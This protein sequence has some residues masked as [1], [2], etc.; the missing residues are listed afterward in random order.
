ME[1][2]ILCVSNRDA[3]QGYLAKKLME[4]GSTVVLCEEF[5]PKM[6]EYDI[7]LL[8]VILKDLDLEKVTEQLVEGQKVFGGNIP[9]DFWNICVKKGVHCYDY[10]K[11]E[12]IAVKNAIA[13]AEGA[14]AEAI[15]LSDENLHNSRS[16]VLGYGRCGRILA[17]KLQGMK[18]LVTVLEKDEI[19]KAAA[20]AYGFSVLECE[21]EIAKGGYR[22]LFHT[23]PGL[24]LYK[25]Q[26]K[27]LGR[28]TTIIDITS[29]KGGV[30]YEYCKEHG[31][32]AK[33]CSG[34]PGKYAPKTSAEILYQYIQKVCQ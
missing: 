4:D 11:E 19:K 8:P 27:E 28:N 5:C 21:E 15:S 29:G 30:D 13:T 6:E 22:Y 20:K 24:R 26:L 32:R 25:E 9:K 7:I 2:N 34:L 10:M 18:S 16:L 3:R 17:D 31:I 33:L 23:A 14:V 1:K 12:S